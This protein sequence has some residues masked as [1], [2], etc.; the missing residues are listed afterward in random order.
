MWCSVTIM[1]RRTE[2]ALCVYVCAPVRI[3]GTS[4]DLVWI[5]LA[6]VP[7]DP[8]LHRWAWAWR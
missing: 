7:L 1:K 5:S 2:A 6:L 4:A 8:P 3:S